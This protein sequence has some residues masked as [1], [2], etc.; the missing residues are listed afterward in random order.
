LSRRDDGRQVI[1]ESRQRQRENSTIGR[2]LR[3]ADCPSSGW[4]KP[5]HVELSRRPICELQGLTGQKRR[6]VAERS[7]GENHPGR[8]D[9]KHR[10]LF[11]AEADGFRRKMPAA[12]KFRRQHLFEFQ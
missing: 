9:I 1:P 8:I 3:C 4:L 7:G 10:L 5:L 6:I 12:G 11:A 2:H